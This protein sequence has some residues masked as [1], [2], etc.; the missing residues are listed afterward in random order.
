MIELTI[1]STFNYYNTH[2]LHR[3][4]FHCHSVY[5]R[6]IVQD[7]YIYMYSTVADATKNCVNIYRSLDLYAHARECMY[8]L[9]LVDVYMYGVAFPHTF[10]Q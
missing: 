10:I 7:Q 1:A 9:K 3:F 2:L 5:N 4:I 8:V 6:C